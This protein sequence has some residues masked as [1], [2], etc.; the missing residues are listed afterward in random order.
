M[1]LDRVQLGCVAGRRLD[2]QPVPLATS[3]ARIAMPG[4]AEV[5]EALRSERLTAEL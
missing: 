5:A 2:D 4:R 1:E 3:Q